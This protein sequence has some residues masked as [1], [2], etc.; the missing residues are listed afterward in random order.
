MASLNKP[1]DFTFLDENGY[2]VVKSVV[3]DEVIQ[4]IKTRV[5]E[6]RKLQGPRWGEFGSS[7]IRTKLIRRGSFF[8][9]KFY[10]G[11]FVAVR[12]LLC[13]VIR[14]FPQVRQAMSLYTRVPMD[15][16]RTSTLQREI[17]QMMLC[18]VE[19]MDDPK[20][21]RVCDLVN[22]GEIF[23]QFYQ[24]KRIL[25]LVEHVIGGDFKLSSLN[26]RDPQ[27]GIK[28]SRYAL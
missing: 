17:R 10:D 5:A 20:D 27:K 15:Y 3:S 16:Q 7:Q 4:D 13:G 28:K 14:V 19:Q 6:I 25:E 18:I 8:W 2:L 12:L 23:D 9:L 24:N 21:K 1:E 11:L 22:C 26:L